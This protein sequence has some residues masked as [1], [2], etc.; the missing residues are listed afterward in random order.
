[1]NSKD[2]FRKVAAT[3]VTAAKNDYNRKRDHF[4]QK[5]VRSELK[6][7]AVPGVRLTRDGVVEYEGRSMP[8]LGARAT[9]ESSGS[10]NRRVTMTRM[11]ATGVL[12][13]LAWQKKQD[14]RE[15]WLTIENDE[16]VF[17]IPVPG[18]DTEAAHELA[19]HIRMVN[20]RAQASN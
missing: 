19:N 14:D 7:G 15:T 9:V 1:M 2:M 17:L 12:P 5:T 16:D 11:L 6:V 8:M 13:A 3:A 10:V 4:D 20:K 18:K